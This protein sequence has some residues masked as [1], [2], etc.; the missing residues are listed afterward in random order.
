MDAPALS[1]PPIS[2]RDRKKARTRSALVAVAERLFRDQGYEETTLEQ[3]CAEVEV[4]VRTLL[5]Y[6]DSKEHIAL[7]H[8][9]DALERFR[10]G[11]L[12]PSRDVDALTYWRAFVQDNARRAASDPHFRRHLELCTTVAA[13]TPRWLAIAGEL[14]DLLAAALAQEAAGTPDAA[15]RARLLAALLV[16]G[17]TAV[18]RDWVTSGGTED[19]EAVCLAVVDYAVERLAV[20]G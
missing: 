17:S 14:E 5:R 19:L 20:S 8:Q 10:A 4:H 2:L 15:F 18:L 9:Y 11:L 16:G 7:A 12:S 13:L 1:T 3:I 6:F